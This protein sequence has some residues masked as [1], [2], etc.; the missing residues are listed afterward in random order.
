MDEQD[1]N[2][3]LITNYQLPIT[4]YQL[5]ITYSLFTSAKRLPTTKPPRC[6]Q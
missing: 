3:N 4:N 2:K 5:P 6:A 1:E